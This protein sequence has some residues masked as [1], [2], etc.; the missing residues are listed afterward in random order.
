MPSSLPARD[1]VPDTGRHAYDRS[2]VEYGDLVA[3]LE[4]TGMLARGAFD[5]C[6]DDDVP[7]LSGGRPARAVVMVGNTGGVD[8]PMWRRFSDE[9]RDEPDPLD[10][11]TRR[12]LA[13]IA[14]RF[15]A[16]LIHPSDRPFR[17][18]QRW[19]QRAADVWPSPIGLLVDPDHGVWHALRGAF[20]FDTGIT[21]TP[22]TGTAT[23]PCVGCDQPCLTACP[24]DA[25][26]VGAYDHEVC[27]AHVRSGT[28]PACATRGCA[29]RLACPVHPD[30][31]YGPEQMR[32]HM[33][34]FVGH[35]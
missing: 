26:T 7:D 17:P 11:W 34:A 35:D 29:A 33:A 8:G 6:P 14:E 18:F 12:V 2:V 22:L 1:R 4:P 9:R 28:E 16:E 20:V 30:G 32:F 3:A 10:A 31:V 23:S 19:A 15:G 5:V 24:V 27:R 25:F 13:P 21:G